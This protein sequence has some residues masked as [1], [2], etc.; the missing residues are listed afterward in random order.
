MIE[1][2]FCPL[3]K[4]ECQRNCAWAIRTCDL[5]EDGAIEY[6]NCAVYEIG[7]SLFVEGFIEEFE[8]DE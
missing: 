1:I 5:T 6:F 7:A 2:A 8:D 4:G 3:T